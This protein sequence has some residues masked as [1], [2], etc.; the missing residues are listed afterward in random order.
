MN[1][2]GVRAKAVA[3]VQLGLL[4]LLCPTVGLARNFTFVTLFDSRLHPIASASAASPLGQADVSEKVLKHRPDQV[5]L[6][7]L[8]DDETPARNDRSKGYR[9]AP[10]MGSFHLPPHSITLQNFVFPAIAGFAR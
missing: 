1:K 7:F 3:P 2:G 5:F 4:I 9:K 6:I 10:P 8:P